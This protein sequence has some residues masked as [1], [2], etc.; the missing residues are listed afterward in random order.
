[1]TYQSAQRVFHSNKALLTNRFIRSAVLGLFTY[2]Q[3]AADISAERRNFGHSQV[4]HLLDLA[5]G[6]ERLDALTYNRLQSS[7]SFLDERI[8]DCL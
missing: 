5:V 6:V 2:A 7:Q 1:M 8:V 3:I 4:E